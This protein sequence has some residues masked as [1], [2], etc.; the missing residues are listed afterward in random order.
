MKN[1]KALSQVVSAVILILL[2]I[3]LIAGI[4]MIVD[5]TV[6]DQLEKGES[7]YEVIDKVEINEEYTCYNSS[8]QIVQV[9]INVGEID[10]D[11][12]L[13]SISQESSSKVFEL[14]NSSK[15]IPDVTNYPTNSSGVKMPSRESGKTYYVLNILEDPSKI[16]LSPKM[17]GNQCAVASSLKEI[18]RCS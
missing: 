18:K 1:K 5:K 4:W 17:N 10:L 2:S 15:D 13:V 14:T 16:E 9:S 8:G 11:S 3:A 7:C 6:N 12:I